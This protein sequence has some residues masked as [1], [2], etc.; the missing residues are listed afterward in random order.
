[1]S[2]FSSIVH[3]PATR[4]LS[5]PSSSSASGSASAVLKSGSFAYISN[6]QSRPSSTA[7][8]E[9]NALSTILVQDPNQVRLN[10]DCNPTLI[11]K[12]PAQTIQQI[13]N[14]NLT[15]LK[16]PALPQPGD[17]TIIQEQD[18]QLAPVPALHRIERPLSPPCLSPVN[19]RERPPRVPQQIPS[20]N[21]LI[22]GKV[23][24]PPDRQV[25]VERLPQ[26]PSKPRD[27]NIERW[28]G[29]QRRTRNVVFRPAVPLIPLPNPKNVIIQWSPADV[30]VRKQYINAGVVRANP[31][32]YCFNS[33]SCQLRGEP[34]NVP[35]GEVLAAHQ[36]QCCNNDLPLLV[37]D[38]AALRGLDLNCH[39]LSEYANQIN[40][41]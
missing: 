30:E 1:M 8:L 9:R 34:F 32:N 20:K 10:Q 26:Q 19:L 22:P 33:E 14:V 40:R 25:I 41:C 4:Q 2:S 27:I 16:P 5:S 23:L 11:Q 37:G 12:K 13:Q 36:D 15:L 17:I 29:Y 7:S 21:I 31:D 3:Y 35:C 24:S 18:R 6:S 38:V 28:L 39:G